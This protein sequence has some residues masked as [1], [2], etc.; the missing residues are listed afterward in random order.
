MAAAMD[1]EVFHTRAVPTIF[2]IGHGTARTDDFL[3]ALTTTGVRVL[4]D[5]R[6][7]PGSRRN[8]QFG[9]EALRASLEAAGITYIHLRGLGGRR[10]PV[11]GSPHTALRVAAFRAYAD[12]MDTEAFA[13]GYAALTELA[14]RSPAAVM[15]AETLW[16][17]CHRRLLADRLAA[18]G[19]TV[20]HLRI[21]AEPEP[22]R[23]TDVARLLQGRLRYGD[24]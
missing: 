21:G 19:W 24:G 2:T 13:A 12:H 20:L 15:C 23:M 8:P 3:A 1:M 17:R 7:F 6:S 5:V 14:G 9:A 11:A 22:H 10:T 16:W 4:A 18:D